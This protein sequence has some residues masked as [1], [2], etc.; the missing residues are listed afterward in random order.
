MT[1]KKLNLQK[2][3]QRVITIYFENYERFK[4]ERPSCILCE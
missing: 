3:L 1:L 4:C 2:Y